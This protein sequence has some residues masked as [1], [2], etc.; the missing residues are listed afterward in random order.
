MKGVGHPETKFSVPSCVII[1]SLLPSLQSMKSL[2]PL[3]SPSSFFPGS[4][5]HQAQASP[6][7]S[8]PASSIITTVTSLLLGC[9]RTRDQLLPLWLSSHWSSI[10]HPSQ[11]S[12]SQEPPAPSLM[13]F[14]SL[15]TITS[16]DEFL[17]LFL[18]WSAA[19]AGIEGSKA[20]A[21]GLV[22]TAEEGPSSLLPCWNRGSPS[23]SVKL[24]GAGELFLSLS[25]VLAYRTIPVSNQFFWWLCI[26]W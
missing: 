26:L 22:L 21:G 25:S 6:P 4:H 10:N 19:A 13:S 17:L 3:P 24:P 23:L 16:F 14:D 5:H 12:A 7:S 1:F 11:A 8:F 18:R 15:G 2:S 9:T 20:I